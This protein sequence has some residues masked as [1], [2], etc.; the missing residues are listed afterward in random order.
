MSNRTQSD[1]VLGVVVLLVAAA[2]GWAAR[3][4]AAVVSYEPVGPRAFPLLLA[5]LLAVC[6]AWLALR[7]SAQADFSLASLKPVMLC[8]AAIVIY[9]G[10]FQL[11]GFI[12]AT[13]L[14]AV[15]VGRLFGGSLRQSA[16]YGALLGA[17][18][19]V[20]FDVLLDVILPLGVLKPLFVIV[21]LS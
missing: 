3:D 1:R 21:V 16:V 10:L 13:A 14:M 20:M 8:A 6:G 2:M 12:I 4:Y 15:P 9:A 7:P 18:L 17:V 11:L 5:A 19:Y